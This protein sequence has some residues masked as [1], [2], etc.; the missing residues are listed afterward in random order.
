MTIADQRG[1][2]VE[3]EVGGAAQVT[4]TFR[5]QLLDQVVRRQA[6]AGTAA[7]LQGATGGGD[8][9][10]SIGN[11]QILVE[12]V[13]DPVLEL[14]D[15]HIGI[16]QVRG[17]G[18]HAQ[19]WALV[20][21]EIAGDRIGEAGA[22]GGEQAD[23]EIDVS[24]G[25][26]RGGDR[27][28]VNDH[29][30]HVQ[31]DL[32]IA[33]P[34]LAG[35]P[36]AGR[37]Y[38][39]VKGAS[40]GKDECASAGCREAWAMV[41]I[42]QPAAQ[43]ADRRG[44]E[45]LPQRRCSCGA[46]PRHDEDVELGEQPVVAD[47]A[48][49]H[50][51]EASSGLH[52]RGA[53]HDRHR[54]R[55]DCWVDCCPQLLGGAQN[56]E[57]GGQA[58]VEAPRQR[59]DANLHVAKGSE[60]VASPASL[61]LASALMKVRMLDGGHFT[62]AA[63]IWR[64]GEDLERQVR[65]P[66]PV[67]LIETATERVLVDTGLHPGAATDAKRHYGGA[68]SLRAFQLELEEGLHSQ[69]DFD[70]LT[71]VVLTHL[72]FDHAGGLALLPPRLPI[73][74]QRREWQAAQDRVAIAKNFYL[75]RDYEGIAERLVIV[76]GDY[77]LLSDGSIELLLTPGHTP[78][79]QSVRIGGKLLIGGDVTHFASGLDDHRFPIFGDDLDAQRASAERLRKLRDAGADVR[80]GHD[81]AVLTPGPVPL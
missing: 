10:G 50:Q 66:I 56:V 33:A 20:D 8:R 40:L 70:T 7:P 24:E 65:F 79:H 16:G 75:P 67:Y 9:S 31:L 42:R 80:P 78:G 41:A 22:G 21:Q 38:A 61:G 13:A 23:A 48:F 74:I 26:A 37:G 39:C 53:A 63:G 71:K 27:T 77:D 15:Q 35:K 44:G 14:A 69:V 17:G 81:P 6:S 32:G 54:D 73:F 45:H 46:K 59:S 34:E 12:V 11:S 5:P 3:A 47:L 49:W 28:C 58:R 64:R 68:E 72:H 43:T 4:G 60:G 2:L 25:G 76:D 62:S 1:D 57:K 29:A 30:G 51:Q 19:R 36:P 55:V 18:L 52:P